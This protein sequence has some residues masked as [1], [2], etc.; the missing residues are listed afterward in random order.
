M[1]DLR[2]AAGLRLV[3]HD[4]VIPGIGIR[5]QIFLQVARSVFNPVIAGQNL[6]VIPGGMIIVSDVFA[7]IIDILIAIDKIGGSVGRFFRLILSGQMNRFIAGTDDDMPGVPGSAAGSLHGDHFFFPRLLRFF[8]S[9]GRPVIRQVNFLKFVADGLTVF[10]GDQRSCQI[11]WLRI[12]AV[13]GTV[14][15]R[16]GLG[17]LRRGGGIIGRLAGT[18]GTGGQTGCHD[19]GQR[20]I[21]KFL[22]AF[23]F[24]SDLDYN[25]KKE[26][27]AQTDR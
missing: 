26:A 3:Q 5:G 19:E 2:F 21:Q 9:I 10:N 24:L 25:G 6:F 17:G 1:H 14:F 13:V 7:E 23:S 8:L 16:G 18:G 12:I 11:G 4:S 20:P 15:Q 27:R 22:H